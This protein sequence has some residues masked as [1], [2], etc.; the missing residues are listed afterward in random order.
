MVM[1]RRFVDEEL[2]F[3]C[4]IKPAHALRREVGARQKLQPVDSG[5]TGPYDTGGLADSTRPP[6]RHPNGSMPQTL[7]EHFDGDC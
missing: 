7:K 2:H 3:D 6:S 4:R 5:G 1:S